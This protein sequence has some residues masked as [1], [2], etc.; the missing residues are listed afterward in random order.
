MIKEFGCFGVDENVLHAI[1]KVNKEAFIRN[2]ML[3]MFGAHGG[4]IQRFILRF[5]HEHYREIAIDTGVRYKCVLGKL[6]ITDVVFF[7]PPHPNCRCIFEP[8]EEG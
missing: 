8:E 5:K 6:V 3:K 4:R 1:V 2:E 7:N